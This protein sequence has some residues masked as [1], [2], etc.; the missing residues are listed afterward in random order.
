MGFL[1]N[2]KKWTIKTMTAPLSYH[3]MM[4]AGINEP[5]HS[6]EEIMG[7]I[8]LKHAFEIASFHA[9]DEWYIS[10]DLSEKDIIHL[11][12]AEARKIGI[13]VSYKVKVLTGENIF[14]AVYS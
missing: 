5:S 1:K 14:Y 3:I 8:S 10:R 11:V 6:P 13:E 7:K 9:K 4:A 12:V 2:Q